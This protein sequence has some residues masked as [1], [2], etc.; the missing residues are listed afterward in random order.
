MPLFEARNLHKRFGDRVV[1]EDVSLSFD[2]GTV[3]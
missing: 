2:E 1:L 3:S